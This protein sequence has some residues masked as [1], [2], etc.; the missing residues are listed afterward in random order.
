MKKIPSAL[1]IAAA[2]MTVIGGII[3]LILA[4]NSLGNNVNT[5]ILFL[6]GG[7]AQVFWALPMIR[8][9]GLPWYLVG[10]GGTAVLVAIW[11]ITR[12]A[13]NPITGRGGAIS[14]N[15]VLVETMQVAYIALTVVILVFELR[16]NK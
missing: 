14:Q 2:V 8:R 6:V 9:W 5:G 11:V 13:G 12:I 16:K 15:G 1:Y 3:H 10:I 7:A 4:P